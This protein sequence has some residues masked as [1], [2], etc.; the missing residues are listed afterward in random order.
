[1]KKNN[2]RLICYF[3][4][5]KKSFYGNNNAKLFSTEIYV[6]KNFARLC[7]K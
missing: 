6:L 7:R 4:L 1:M 2:K 5:M 3:G